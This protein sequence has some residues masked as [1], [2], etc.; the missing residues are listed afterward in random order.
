MPVTVTSF[1]VKANPAIPFLMRDTD[2]RGGLRVVPDQSYL[3]PLSENPSAIPMGARVTGMI[4]VTQS[5]NHLHQLQSDGVFEDMG[6]LGASS[7]IKNISAPLVIDADGN[8]TVE[9]GRTLPQEGNTGDVLRLNADKMPIWD[10]MSANP[11]QGIRSTVSK[12]VPEALGPSESFDF[13]M[14]MG[15]TNI[16]LNVEIDV[17]QVQV[18]AYGDP[19]YGESNPYTFK[20]RPGQL[21]DDGSRLLSDGS[22][23]FTRRYGFAANTEDPVSE[24]IYWRITNFGNLPVTPTVTIT[25]TAIE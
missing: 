2:L 17:P 21:F 19:S 4:V 23:Q 16:L 18:E 14:M 6:V 5:D 12:T 22:I 10:P 15:R 11:G 1:F 8:L 25:Y 7:Q 9:E 20:S 13:S 24:T 3:Q